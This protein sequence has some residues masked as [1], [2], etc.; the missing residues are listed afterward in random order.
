MS[1][2]K[3]PNVGDT[4]TLDITGCEVVEGQYGEQVAFTAKDDIL[5]LPVATAERQLSRLGT[6]GTSED[7]T[8]DYNLV[9]GDRLT[10]SR[11]KSTK[12]GGKPFWNISRGNGKPPVAKSDRASGV[13]FR[14]PTT[15]NVPNQQLP[16]LLQNQEAED[17]KELADKIGS[18]KPKM[19]EA[20]KSLTEWVIAEI[21]PLYAKADYG[22]SP[23]G[24]AACVAT[25]FIQACKSGKVE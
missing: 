17:A 25:L 23:E 6:Y 5:Y 4:A 11:A 14:V 9:I 22:I 12:P 20:Y 19:R 3:L 13:E 8:L 10:F 7:G 24:M 1:I 2:L 16:P 21:A 15:S 18:G